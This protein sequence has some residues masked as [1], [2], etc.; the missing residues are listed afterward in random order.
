MKRLIKVTMTLT[1]IVLVINVT[2]AQ[3]GPRHGNSRGYG[4][5]AGEG[6]EVRMAGLNLTD[7][8]QEQMRS[9]RVKTQKELLP[10]KNKL[11]EN[12]A[13]MKTLSTVDSPWW[14]I[15]VVTA[16]GGNIW[17]FIRA[18]NPRYL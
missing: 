2:S 5:G 7:E 3:Q 8:Q 1:M 4:Q 17:I 12:K 13:K 15:L 10:I 16:R 11:G 18:I 14:Q 6:K 9:M